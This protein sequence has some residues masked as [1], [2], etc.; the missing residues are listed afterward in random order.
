MRNI[1]N[2][3]RFDKINEEASPRLPKSEEY[4]LKKGKSGKN[5]ALY[6]HDDMDGIFSAIEVKKYLLNAGFKIVKYG[7]LNYSEGWKYTELDPKLI[8]VVLDFSDMPGDER[9]EMVD[10][11]LDHH[12]VF[13]PE[14]LEKY[15]SSPVQKKKTASAYEAICQSLGVPQDDL[16]LSVIDMIDAAKYDDYDVSWQRLL[17]FNISDIKRKM[18]KRL[19]FGAAFNQFIKRSDTKTVVSVINYCNDAS[20]FAVFNAMKRLYPEHNSYVGGPKKGLKKDFIEDSK[21]RLGEM[22][23]RTRGSNSNMKKKFTTQA[24]FVNSFRSG[25]GIKPN[26]YQLIGDLI[27]VPG[28]T[29]ANAL[30]A[31]TIIEKDF[32]DNKIEAEPKFIMLIYGT[33]IQVCSYK[34]MEKTSDLPKLQNGET[35]NDLGKYMIGLLNNFKT[36]L[37]YD[38]TGTSIGQDE[39]TVSGG[40]GGIGTISNI[41]GV[42]NKEPYN[43]LRFIDMF[44]NKIITDLSGVRFNLNLKW[45]EP[46]DWSAGEPAMNNRV[47]N[48][49]DV[50]KLDKY[51]NVKEGLE[52][53][54]IDDKTGEPVTVSKEEFLKAGLNK[55]MKSD[56]MKIDSINNRIIAKF[57][58]FNNK[59]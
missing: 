11:Y 59:L 30:R 18:N 45:S 14:E 49:D 1:E 51:G 32:I 37:G 46:A 36:H 43:G 8:N 7:V 31:R 35:V 52:Y 44:K 10:Y 17:D 20:I 47:I 3:N 33:T 5:V 25:E 2:F 58:N 48:I 57:E 24:D 29:W 23:K 22:E 9:D 4:W 54:I 13:T 42:C 19:E 50:T 6:T 26:G 12:G 28:G 41:I 15:K 56:S 27:F 38:S 34:K 16:T 39:V 40:H 21:W 53:N 55:K